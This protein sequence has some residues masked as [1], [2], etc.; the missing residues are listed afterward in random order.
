[1]SVRAFVLI[2]TEIEIAKATDVVTALRQL[3]PGV[4][5][6]DGVTGPYDII[7]E[8]EAE[9]LSDIM[10]L[11]EEQ[12]RTTRGVYRIVTFLVV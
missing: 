6:A 1:M 2:Q 11:I 7:A 8:L 4:K 9:S 10:A 3:G 5:S 12:I